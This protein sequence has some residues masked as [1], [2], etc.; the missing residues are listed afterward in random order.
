MGIEYSLRFEYRDSANVAELLRRL[1]GSREDAI[2]PNRFEFRAAASTA[3]MP[4]AAAMPEPGGL[5]FCDYGGSGRHF[6]GTVLAQIV[7]SFGPVTI[8][9]L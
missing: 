1:E 7:S 6:L 3:V 8:S 9:E 2:V 4:D 5:Y